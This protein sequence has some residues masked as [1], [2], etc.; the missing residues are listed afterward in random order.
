MGLGTRTVLR[1]DPESGMAILIA[2]MFAVIVSGII[3]SGTLMMD[4]HSKRIQV[5]FRVEAQ[6]TRIARSG[7]TDALNWM[8]RQTSQP[9]TTFDPDLD[10][11]A[12]PKVLDT[13]EPETGLVREF[14]IQGSVWGRYEVWKEWATDPDLERL[15][16]RQNYQCRDVSAERG[17]SSNGTAWLLRS[18]GYVFL[19]RDSSRRYNAQPN[20]V[21]AS[22]LLGAEIRRLT[23]QPPS[24]TAV[25]VRNGDG[26]G[27]GPKGRIRGG[28]LGGS[29]YHQVGSPSTGPPANQRV[30]P[31]PAIDPAYDAS[32][33]KVFGVE[34]N[35]LRGMA[36][37]VITS[38]G[39]FPDPIPN[40]SLVYCELPS[41]T[42]T[43]ARALKG[44]GVVY[45]KGNVTL[46]PGSNS[47]F[48][49][50]LYVDGDLAIREPCE[51]NGSVVATGTL[52]LRGS[53]DYATINFDADILN[54]LRIEIGQYRMSGGVR[55]LRDE[56]NR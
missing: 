28:A 26:V 22:V 33:K 21:L 16:W 51:I 23:L 29:I 43:S 50:L 52:A 55:D 10:M 20:R 1:R 47:N 6:A 42:F 11:L 41:I 19:R 32:V 13:D 27:I 30:I 14:Q 56:D 5:R 8:R 36:D 53:G 37:L 17:L 24:Q 38:A 46:D 25:S 54:A 48:G 4:S 31:D 12:D 15:A 49:G 7:L 9:V 39:D 45:I 40:N 3:Y 2:L 35:E 34:E 44:T 18:V